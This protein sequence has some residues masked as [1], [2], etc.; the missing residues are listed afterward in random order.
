MAQIVFH[1][2]QS[3]P[4]WW[5]I[6]IFGAV[7]LMMG[8]VA[9][10]SYLTEWDTMPENE[11]WSLLTL[12][13][14]PLGVSIIFFIGMDLR[15]SAGSVDFRVYPFKKKYKSIPMAQVSEIELVTLKGIRSFRKLGVNR[16]FNRREYNFGSPHVLSVKL[17]NGSHLTFSTFKPRELAHFLN[18]LPKEVPFKDRTTSPPPH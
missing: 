14:G 15:I 18:N 7:V 8:F 16:R 1:E 13:I 9:L 10:M 11:K 5:R 4:S 6:L 12:L 3:I 2:K 17:K